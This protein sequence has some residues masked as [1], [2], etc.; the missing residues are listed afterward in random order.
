MTHKRPLCLFGDGSQ[1]A[2]L[3]QGFAMCKTYEH[4]IGGGEH[5]SYRTELSTQVR[6][7]TD[8]VIGQIGNGQT[9][10]HLLA[11]V[12]LNQVGMQWNALIGFI[13][14]FYL[15]LVAKCKFDSGKAWKLVARC[16]AAVFEAT[17]IYRSKV[18]LLEDST[19]LG[20]K[21]S[22][23]WATFQTH[24]VIQSFIDVQFQSH[25]KIVTEISLFMVRERV[26]PHEIELLA[27]KCKKAEEG[28][29]KATTELKKLQESQG[30]LKRK[31]DALSAEFKILKTKVK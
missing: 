10:A 20:Q 27:T 6:V 3:D 16:V 21:A 29:I 15:D 7:Y 28:S 25:S 24:R 12:L 18:I 31:H 19:K 22:F 9:P 30:E 14:T 13:D 2:R 4:W 23:M 1:L 5:V 17:Q 11:H 26:D 8:G